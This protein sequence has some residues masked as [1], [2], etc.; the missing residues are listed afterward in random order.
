MSEWTIYILRRP[1]AMF[2]LI[3]CK[4]YFLV[5]N[6]DRVNSRLPTELKKKFWK[7]RVES[8]EKRKT[9]FSQLIFNKT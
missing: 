1:V 7:K 6:K 5:W 3:T 9:Q 2:M 8:H 4:L